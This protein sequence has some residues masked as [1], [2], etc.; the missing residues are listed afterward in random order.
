MATYLNLIKRLMQLDE[1]QFA[2]RASTMSELVLSFR[3]DPVVQRLLKAC[4]RLRRRW[5]SGR[6]G[7]NT[8]PAMRCRFSCLMRTEA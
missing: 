8:P 4:L 3:N 2:R 6:I 5:R 7:R 1:A